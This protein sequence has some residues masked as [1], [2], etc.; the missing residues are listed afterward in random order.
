MTLCFATHNEHKIAEV[1]ALVGKSFSLV[2]L[3]SIGCREELAEEQDTLPGNAWQKAHYV[4]TRYQTPCFADD[5]GLEVETLGGAPGVFSARYAGPQRNAHNNMALLLKNLEGRASRAARF[6]TVI[7]LM[8]DEQPRYFEGVLTGTIGFEPRG[9]HGFGYDPVF[10]PDGY[11]QTLA[12]LPLHEK[13][14]I[15]HRARAMAAFVAYLQ[16][17]K[18]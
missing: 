5:T 15:S 18:S 9:H 6:R 8:A 16:T 12:E 3:E 11:P 10:L 14:K 4:F 13:N 7:C 2:G 1:Q 17:L